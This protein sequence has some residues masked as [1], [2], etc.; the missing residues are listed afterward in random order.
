MIPIAHLP[1]HSTR[2]D[3]VPLRFLPNAPVMS[4]EHEAWKAAE[5]NSRRQVDARDYVIGRR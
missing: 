1:W 4:A 5:L 2:A 3:I